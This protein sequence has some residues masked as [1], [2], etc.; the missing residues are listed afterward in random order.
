MS[1][2]TSTNPYTG[3]LI[4]SYSTHS[5]LELTSILETAHSRFNSWRKT[6]YTERKELMLKLAKE[7]E[8]NKNEYAITITREMGKPINQSLAEIAK[9]A[10]LC[11]YYAEEAEAHLADQFVETDADSSYVTYEPLGIVLAVMPWNYPFW[12]VFRFAVPA[13]MAG[14]VGLLKHA[15]NVFGCALNIE[16]AFLDAGFPEGCFTTLLIGNSKVESILS[17]SRVKAVTLTGSKPAGSKVASVAGSLVK[18]SVLELGGNNALIVFPD[19]DLPATVDTCVN[20]RFQNTGQSCIA[21]KR[22]LVHQD[23]SEVFIEKLIQKVETLQ[24]GNPEDE[25]TFI[26][27]MAR[28]DLA[29]EL[30]QQLRETIDAGATLLLGGNREGALFEPTLVNNVTPAMRMFNEETFGPALA[31]TSFSSLE[32]AIALSNNSAFGLGV[33]IFTSDINAVRPYLSEFEEGAVFINELVKSD[34]R[35]PF[36]G[37]KDSGYGRELG[38]QGIL[39]FVNCKTVYIKA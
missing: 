32:E 39:E 8:S 7:L 22:L 11:R 14:N 38:K 4:A 10:W 16:K 36:G 31:I 3:E 19:C 17:D 33:S 28:E 1:V 12:Q 6:S 34:P 5:D 18:K 23:I 35:L 20:A 9:C 2:K 25:A 29:V 37:I 30:E 24:T 27:P 15:S 13:L 26:G 21:G